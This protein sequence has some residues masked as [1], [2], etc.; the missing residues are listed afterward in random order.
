MTTTTIIILSGSTFSI[1]ADWSSTNSIICIGPGG[2]GASGTSQGGGQGGGFGQKNNLTGLTPGS[3]VNIQIGAAGSAN[4]TFFE[5]NSNAVVAQGD[6]GAPGSGPTGGAR[7]QTNIGDV[8]YSGGNGGSGTGSGSTGSGGGGGAGGSHGNGGTGANNSSFDGGGAGG[9]DNGGNGVA[10]GAG[11]VAQDGTAGGAYGLN[12]GQPGSHGSGGGAARNAAGGKG[13]AGIGYTDNSGGANNGLTI[14]P[15][16]GGG[17]T[18][19]AVGGAGGSYGG[20]GGGGSTGGAAAPGAIIVTYTIQQ[21]SVGLIAGSL[22][23]G[24]QSLNIQR[25][26]SNAGA[27][28]AYWSAAQVGPLTHANLILREDALTLTF[29]PDAGST[30][31]YLFFAFEGAINSNSSLFQAW[32]NDATASADLRA[33]ARTASQTSPTNYLSYAGF[34][35]WTSPASPVSQTFKIQYA[36]SALGL[37]CTIRNLFMVALKKAATDQYAESLGH[38]TSTI[39]APANAASLTFTPSAGDFIVFGSA[40]LDQTNTSGAIGAELNDS[41]A[42]RAP[43][44]GLQLS[45]Q[46]GVVSASELV[47][48][49]ALIWETL[50]ASSQT[51]NIAFN[52]QLGSGT[53]GIANVN[54]LAMRIDGFFAAYLATL[55]N[56]YADS[57]QTSY[58]DVLTLTQS[59]AATDH[60]VLASWDHQGAGNSVST[61]SQFT[62]AGAT[63]SEAIRQGLATG[64][65]DNFVG[66]ISLQSGLSGST[67]WKIQAKTQ[68][69]GTR[70]KVLG[71]AIIAALQLGSIGVSRPLAVGTLSLS[72][73]AAALG[74]NFAV[75]IG[76][77][78]LS[79]AAMVIAKTSIISP[80]AG[81]LTLTGQTPQVGLGKVTLIVGALALTPNTITADFGI[82]LIA[83]ALNIASDIPVKGTGIFIPSAGAIILAG[84]AMSG[85]EDDPIPFFTG[86]LALTGNTIAAQDFG[87]PLVIGSLALVGNALAVQGDNARPLAAGALTLASAA[88]TSVVSAPAF[89][90]IG[91]LNLTGNIALIG[92]TNV[93]SAGALA[94][95]GASFSIDMNVS[96]AAKTLVLTGAAPIVGL[97]IFIASTPNLALTGQPFSVSAGAFK[98]IIFPAGALALTGAGL[99]LGFGAQLAAGTLSLGPTAFALDTAIPMQAGALA[100]TGFIPSFAAGNNAMISIP[101]G[102]LQIDSVGAAMMFNTALIAGGLTLTG[103]LPSQDFAPT[104]QA[105]QLSLASQAFVVDQGIPLFVGALTLAGAPLTPVQATVNIN[106]VVGSLGLLGNAPFFDLDLSLAAGAL[107]FVVQAPVFDTSFALSQAVMTLTGAGM[108]LD[109][110][111]ALN[112]GALSLIGQA[113]TLDMNFAIPAGALVLSGIIPAATIGLV[114]NLVAGA[115]ALNGLA[116]PQDINFALASGA[117]NLTAYGLGGNGAVTLITG[118]LSLG[119]GAPA[120]QFGLPM[121]AG[122][123]NFS[124]QTVNAIAG[125]MKTIPAGALTLAGADIHVGPDFRFP[126]GVLRI[127]GYPMIAVPALRKQPIEAV[128]G[129]MRNDAVITRASLARSPL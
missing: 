21:P 13:G 105:G 95:S 97:G 86:A 126:Q 41:F 5:D 10:G 29:T 99:Q 63:K 77:L 124:G 33:F 18:R 61:Y 104:L 66:S 90:D 22:S 111:F 100:L 46:V 96:N 69:A 28:R 118:V 85:L 16:G 123:L 49:N 57:T 17:G 102:A 51:F 110:G 40:I 88:G 37:T 75:P 58:A 79:S 8:T 48:F 117:L 127:I 36:P 27:T 45:A 20:G 2:K 116:T 19:G 73:Q 94:L 125:V 32:I 101:D 14:G 59:L 72:G 55:G 65:N 120:L 92:Q 26:Y 91:A 30:D 98:N 76:A 112:G 114:A 84:A 39:T 23:L 15:G 43:D 109:L 52:A 89:F 83:G 4:A 9:S 81:A 74:L 60:L 115:L 62:Q 50:P 53:A 31:Y 25:N 129:A 7:T 82:P 78:A 70:V 38:Q 11:G 44:D 56:S 3:T 103:I 108:A 71:N 80:S 67:T 121:T 34:L 12:G 6:Y 113:G 122:A 42:M 54:I 93:F 106:L 107:S 35:K 68:T 1:P 128:R 24:N 119:S 64:A 47:P 87:F